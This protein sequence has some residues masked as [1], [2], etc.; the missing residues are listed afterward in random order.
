MKISELYTSEAHDSGAEFEVKDDL[1]NPTGLFIKVVGVDSALFRAQTKNSKKYT[2]SLIAI[3][4]ILM[5]RKCLQT[6]LLV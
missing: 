4:K 2:L 3:I 5:T 1:G 6:D